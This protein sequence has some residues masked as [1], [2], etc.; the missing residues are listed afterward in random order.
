MNARC[1]EFLGDPSLQNSSRLPAIA[2]GVL[3]SVHTS[4]ECQLWASLPS[5]A[6]SDVHIGNL[7]L[8]MGSIY[9]I[10]MGKCY[11]PG[12]FCWE[13]A[14]KHLPAHHYCSHWHYT[15]LWLSCKT[16]GDPWLGFLPP[17]SWYSAKGSESRGLRRFVFS[18]YVLPHLVIFSPSLGFTST[19]FPGIWALLL[20]W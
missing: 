8:A 10:E 4:S 11:K 13:W 20:S 14:V 3:E 12:F 9:T 1:P 16:L 15:F 17:S 18:S 5:S 7:K 2:S 19:C 6:C